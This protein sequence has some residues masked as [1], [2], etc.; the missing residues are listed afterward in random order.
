MLSRPYVQCIQLYFGRD[1]KKQTGVSNIPR[2]RTD[3]GEWKEGGGGGSFRSRM[4]SLRDV[5]LVTCLFSR[6]AGLSSLL[7]L[8]GCS[9]YD[10]GVSEE[11]PAEQA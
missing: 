3:P 6:P 9:S 8:I 2:V 5:G 4:S 7:C 11:S 1:R 10:R